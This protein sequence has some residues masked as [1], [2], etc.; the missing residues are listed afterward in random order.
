MPTG[1]LT[2]VGSGVQAPAHTTPEALAAI[3]SAEKLFVLVGDRVSAAWLQELSS[4]AETLADAY[5]VGKPRIDTYREMTSRILTAVRAGR[6]VCAVFYGH[7][8]FFV[9]PSHEAVRQAREEGYAARMLPGIST[10]DCLYADVEDVGEAGRD[11]ATGSQIFEATHFLEWDLRFDPGT[12]LLLFQIGAI[13]VRTALAKDRWSKKGLVRLAHRLLDSYPPEHT[14][15]LYEASWY[16]ACRARIRRIPLARLA[17]VTV[18]R[19]TTLYIGGRGSADGELRDARAISPPPAPGRLVVVGTGCRA[20]GQI[21]PE[22]RVYLARAGRVLVSTQDAATAAWIQELRPDALRLPEDPDAAAAET[23]AALRA[24]TTVCLACDGHPAFHRPAAHTLR[25]ARAAGHGARMLP[26]ISRE[27]CLAADLDL[28]PGQDGCLTL[29]AGDFLAR[30]RT[31]QPTAAV[32]VHGAGRLARPQ[33]GR[34]RLAELAGA[35]DRVFP[36]RPEAVVYDALPPLP[37]ERSAVR[38]VPLGALAATGL[39]PA[40]TLYLPAA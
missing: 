10:A 23:L 2:V 6:R 28:D 24:E 33:D 25:Q 5:R 1:C 32:L 13:G 36:G 16:G 38:R 12:A 30:P 9:M 4:T 34:E 29:D 19:T 8:G 22:A 20:A 3:R 31:V 39:D 37:A 27:D 40:S 14:V 11:P 15:V 18:T 17:K 7:P 26:A 21:S 35:L